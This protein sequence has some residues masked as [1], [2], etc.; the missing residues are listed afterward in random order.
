MISSNL[1]LGIGIFFTL[2]GNKIVF[3]FRLLQIRHSFLFSLL[4][5]MDPYLVSDL[6]THLMSILTEL[7]FGLVHFRIAGI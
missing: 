4:D 1:V 7:V 2:L 6:P 3:E 5:I